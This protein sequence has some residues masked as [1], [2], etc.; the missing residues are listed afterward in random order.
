MKR[1]LWLLL[2]T[3]DSAILSTY[4][5]NFIRQQTN[6]CCHNLYPSYHKL[7]EA[8]QRCYPSQVNITETYAEVNLQ[9]LID[10]TIEKICLYQEDVFKSLSKIPSEM[11]FI[12]KWGCDGSQQHRYKQKFNDG[13]SDENIFFHFDGPGTNLF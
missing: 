8:K 6:K 2:I 10:H 4:Q 13:H 3:L 11:V 7:K 12:T 1:Y 5:Y 9:S